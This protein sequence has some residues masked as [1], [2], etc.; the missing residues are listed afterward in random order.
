MRSKPTDDEIEYYKYYSLKAGEKTED[1]IDEQV[2]N[3]HKAMKDL[4]TLKLL[5]KIQKLL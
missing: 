5:P 2:E 4:R 3:V 1:M